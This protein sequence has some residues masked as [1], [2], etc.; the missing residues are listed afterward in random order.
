MY[1]ACNNS[2]SEYII[3]ELIVDYRK[4]DKSMMVPDQKVLHRGWSF[5]W[6]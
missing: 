4:N 6:K 1:T 2:E 3:M 5:M